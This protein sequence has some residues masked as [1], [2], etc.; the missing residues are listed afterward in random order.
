MKVLF[1]QHGGATRRR[2]VVRGTLRITICDKSDDGR[3]RSHFYS[4]CSND[5]GWKHVVGQ[6][7]NGR[8]PGVLLNV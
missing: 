8:L 6:S 2:R 4:Q 7:G 3:S 5:H 1:S